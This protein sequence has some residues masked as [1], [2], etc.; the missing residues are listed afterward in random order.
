MNIFSIIE[1]QFYKKIFYYQYFL[2]TINLKNRFNI[3]L[4][5]LMKHN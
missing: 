1:L 4:M 2:I 3:I 5:E